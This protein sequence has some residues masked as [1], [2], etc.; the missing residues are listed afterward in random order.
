M[1]LHATSVKTI[2]MVTKGMKTW[3]VK[4]CKVECLISRQPYMVATPVGDLN[5]LR[6]FEGVALKATREAQKNNA[7][8][9]SVL[10]C[11]S[12]TKIHRFPTPAEIRCMYS[13]EV[14]GRA[15]LRIG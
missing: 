13:P 1:R 4:R 5:P 3:A 15:A 10:Q 12:I 2:L 14:T 7:K 9:W 11:H 8:A 6:A